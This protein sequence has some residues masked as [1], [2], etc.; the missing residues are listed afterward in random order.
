MDKLQAI[1]DA[2]SA[3]FL[4]R[5]IAA[6]TMESVAERASVS[7]MTVYGHF[8]DKPSLLSAVFERN[9]KAIRLPDL[10][11]GSDPSSSLAQLAE[12]G[13]RLVSFLTRPEI[14]R[15]A[16]VMARAPTKTRVSRQRFTP[17]VPARC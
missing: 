10:G 3:L 8:R 15:T 1:L 11:V 4:E 16:R 9:I 6:T 2:A 5:G 13:E 7:K 12:F 14:V 17:P